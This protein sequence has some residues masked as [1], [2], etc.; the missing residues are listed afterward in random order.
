M[1]CVWLGL[2]FALGFTIDG[3]TFCGFSDRECVVSYVV[4]G[5]NVSGMKRRKGDKFVDYPKTSTLKAY[6]TSYM[7]FY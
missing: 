5:R 3:C 2:T 4:Y 1:C 6:G 7:W